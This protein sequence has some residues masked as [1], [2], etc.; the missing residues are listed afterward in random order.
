MAF[1]IVFPGEMVKK[2]L[3]ELRFLPLGVPEKKKGTALTFL[4]IL[5]PFLHM[6]AAACVLIVW[7]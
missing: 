1:S 5:A 2:Q 4:D 6:E 3:Y 7:H